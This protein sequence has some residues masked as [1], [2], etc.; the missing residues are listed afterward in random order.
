MLG[1]DAYLL[2]GILHDTPEGTV[3]I[4]PLHLFPIESNLDVMSGHFRKGCYVGQEL[5]MTDSVYVLHS[6]HPQMHPSCR[7]LLNIILCTS[8]S[9]QLPYQTI[10]YHSF[11]GL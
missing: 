5:I 1:S 6:C 10:D 11:D 3:D 8:P 4:L 9:T 2:H 7:P